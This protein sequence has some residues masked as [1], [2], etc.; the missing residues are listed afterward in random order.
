MDDI[1]NLEF[2]EKRKEAKGTT[3]YY[4]LDRLIKKKCVEAKE[5]WLD[6]K[7]YHIERLSHDKNP[8][9]MFSEIRKFTR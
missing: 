8:G 2:N 4:D 3:E 7:C 5:D 9:P 1:R 6:E